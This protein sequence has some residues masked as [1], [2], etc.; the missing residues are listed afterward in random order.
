MTQQLGRAGS[1]VPSVGIV[2]PTHFRP[3]LLARLLESFHVLRYPPQRL[4][5][6]VV[7]GADDPSR[8]V[9]QSFAAHSRFSASYEIVPEELLCS[10]SAKRNMGARRVSGEVVAF[11]DDDCVAH[12]DWL[13]AAV[14][15]FSG[16]TVGGVEGLINVPRPN[17]PTRSYHGSL[18]LRLP[19]GYRTGNILYRRSAFE[20]C[21]GFDESLAYLEDTDLGYS[22]IERGYEIPFAVDAVVDHPVQRA[23]PLTRLRLARTA[24]DLPYL[25]AKHARSKTR[26]RQRLRIFERAHYPYL[27]L[28]A[29]AVPLIV[30]RLAVGATVLGAGLCLLVPLHLAHDFWGLRFGLKEISIMGFAQPIVPIARL[31]W[32]LVGRLEIS[33]GLRKEHK[34]ASR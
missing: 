23:R 34:R 18:Q 9:L 31:L 16:P 25:F 2:V 30:L 5:L 24:R 1:L 19:G 4:D 11:I 14:L 7:G 33:L 21:G 28:Y 17:R 15:F 13:S 6:V 12:P 26:L 22:V 29:V 20:A 3:Q 8:S 10:V 32:W 27:V